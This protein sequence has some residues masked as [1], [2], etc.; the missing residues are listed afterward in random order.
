[1]SAWNTL[2]CPVCK[3]FMDASIHLCSKG[4][5]VCTMCFQQFGDCRICGEKFTEARNWILEKLATVIHYP[6]KY[7]EK[8][9]DVNLTVDKLKEHENE[10]SYSD[11]G[12]YNCWYSTC[13]FSGRLNKMED[14]CNSRHSIC[15]DNL[16]FRYS[17]KPTLREPLTTTTKMYDHLFVIRMK[18]DYE[19]MCFAVQYVGN[20][21]DAREYLYKVIFFKADSCERITITR[22]C[23]K[24]TTPPEEVFLK[25]N[26]ISLTTEMASALTGEDFNNE[27]TEPTEEYGVCLKIKLSYNKE[28]F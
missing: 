18:Q 19:R 22:Y 12:Y 7:K 26:C 3:Q 10:C 1:M 28:L 5:S 13:G 8:G 11:E 20:E 4:H 25:G 15:L 27:D 21:E 17:Y 16:V 23:Q 14:H 9:C 24:I 2:K 6:C